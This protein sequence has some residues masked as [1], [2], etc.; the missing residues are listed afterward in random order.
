MIFKKKLL[1]VL[2]SGILSAC[3]VSSQSPYKLSNLP[4]N[5]SEPLPSTQPHNGKLTDLKNWWQQFNDTQL[6]Q[7]IAAA[8]TASPNIESA[9]ALVV[10]SQAALVLSQAQLLPNVNAEAS[11]SRG[12]NGVLFQEGNAVSGELNATWEL[13][14]W[15]KNKASK[16]EEQA[17]LAGTTAM[18]H[19]ARVIVATETA[20]QYIHYRLCENLRNLA[21]KN[22]ESTTKTQ[23]LSELTEKAGLLSSSAV[24]QVSAE[25]AQA[26]NDA[27]KQSL[28]CT[29]L[30]KSLVAVTALPEAQVRE[31]L[32]KNAGVIPVPES[33]EVTTVPAKTL[34]QRPDVLNAER[35]VDASSFEIAYSEAKRYPRLSLNGS[36]GFAYDTSI[37]DS[38]LNRRGNTFYD[39]MTWS[40]G[41]VALSVPIFDAGVQKANI[42]VAKAQYK[43]A[44]STY[45]SVAR[46]AVREVEEALAT[47]NNT[48]LREVNVNKAAKEFELSFKAAEM[49]NKASLGSLFEL[50]QTRR[51]S[52][53]A[54]ANVLELQKERVIAWISL[55]HAL[56]GGWTETENTLPENTTAFIYNKQHQITP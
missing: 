31:I 42:E 6:S 33:I 56:G 30:L 43:A 49:R 4:S 11:A 48:A 41:P 55:Y 51:L 8:E 53:Q 15:G 19:E 46:N 38:I 7:L 12:K 45:E 54:Q 34:Q 50:E 28:Q 18:W 39:G 17:R 2:I 32:A 16:N 40:I 5:W 24:S 52:F 10:A 37:T 44:K 25:A 1:I 22:V 14:V 47:L 26:M 27:K 20:K 9:R 13:D 3:A 29:L 35:N 23:Q 36:I 21:E